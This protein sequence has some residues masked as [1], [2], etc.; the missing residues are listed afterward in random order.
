MRQV[1]LKFNF[2]VS[3]IRKPKKNST[4]FLDCQPSSL[5]HIFLHFNSVSFIYKQTEYIYMLVTHFNFH[6]CQ[7]EER[8]VSEIIK[9]KITVRFELSPFLH[10]E[11]NYIQEKY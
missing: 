3:R 6:L 8:H 9:N 2:A 7:S 1:F 5:T 10:C 4:L 11:S